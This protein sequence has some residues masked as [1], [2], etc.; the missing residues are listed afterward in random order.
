MINNYGCVPNDGTTCNV[1]PGLDR[2][3]IAAID[4]SVK[5]TAWIT[6]PGGDDQDADC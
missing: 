6:P 1:G 4:K 3:P 5:V 2:E